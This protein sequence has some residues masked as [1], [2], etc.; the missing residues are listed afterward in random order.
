MLLAAIILTL[1]TGWLTLVSGLVIPLVT[2]LA[3]KLEASTGTKS[4]VTIVLAA[5]AAVLMSVVQNHGV[6]TTTTLLDGVTTWGLALAAF[7]GI[8]SPVGTDSKLAPTVGIGPATE[9]Q[10]P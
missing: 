8:W 2:G 3:T 5:L 6:F 4:L 9:P 10:A 7:Y 1:S